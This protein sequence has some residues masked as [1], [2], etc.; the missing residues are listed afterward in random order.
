MLAMAATCCFGNLAFGAAKPVVGSFFGLD[1]MDA[2][3]AVGQDGNLRLIWDYNV[4]K[5]AA[6]STYGSGL[7]SALW[8]LDPN[9]GLVATGSSLIPPSIGSVRAFEYV[10]VSGATTPTFLARYERSNT[11]LFAQPSGNTTVAFLYGLGNS[12]PTNSFGVW[13]FNSSGVLISAASYGPFTGVSISQLV[14]DPSGKIVVKWQTGTSGTGASAGWV[15]NEFGSIENSTA[16]FGPFGPLGKIRLNSSGQ[17]IWPWSHLTSS[18]FVL[19]LWTFDTSG[20]LTNAQ[21]YGPF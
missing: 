20:S 5:F 6:P 21:T 14:F 3:T 4:S 17:Q 13:T 18:G 2:K 7:G 12:F 11:L 16:F 8:I 1:L 9:G 15:L 10:F 19:S